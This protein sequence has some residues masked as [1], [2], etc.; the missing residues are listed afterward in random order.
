MECWKVTPEERVK[1]EVIYGAD[2]ETRKEIFEQLLPEETFVDRRLMNEEN[3][4]RLVFG[5]SFWAESHLFFT[6]LD[7][8]RW[9]LEENEI[10]WSCL[11][12]CQELIAELEREQFGGQGN[13]GPFGVPKVSDP[14]FGNPPRR[15][16][17]EILK[18]FDEEDEAA[19]REVPAARGAD[20]PGGCPRGCP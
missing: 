7:D 12:A 17:F 14:T 1:T 5:M 18:R 16:W 20:A 4:S 9:F 6:L 2:V 8:F 15:F 3:M 19:E 11:C 10:K 13:A